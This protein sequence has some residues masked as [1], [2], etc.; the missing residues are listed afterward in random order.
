[1]YSRG[2]Q[3]KSVKGKNAL[4]I[5]EVENIKRWRG[6]KENYDRHQGSNALKDLTPLGL[7]LRRNSD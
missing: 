2:S 5:E 6:V 7:Q 4:E 3:R 1:M